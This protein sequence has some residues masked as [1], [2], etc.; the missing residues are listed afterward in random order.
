MDTTPSQPLKVSVMQRLRAAG[1]RPTSARIGIY[2]AMATFG[3]EG[4][5]VNVVFQS[6]LRGGTR[7]SISSIYRIM[8]E[9]SD[10]GLATMTL[11]SNR[12]AVYFV[13]FGG[14]EQKMLGFECS[15]TGRL[16]AVA[17]EDLH[18]RLMAVARQLGMELRELSIL[19]RI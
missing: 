6:M 19:V 3:S 14:P 5:T 16:V 17:D 4:V 15:Q 9:F 13:Q 7:A 18:A 8:R 10:H 1:L 11:T 2:Q 12:T